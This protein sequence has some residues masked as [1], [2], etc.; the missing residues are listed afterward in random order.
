M[1]SQRRFSVKSGTE[2]FSFNVCNTA[3]HVQHA[4]SVLSQHTHVM[5]D[6][7]GQ[8]IGTVAGGLSLL[9]LGT[10]MPSSDQSIFVLDMVALQ[11]SVPART[12]LV[13]FL[14]ETDVT[15]VLFDGRMDKIEIDAALGI[16]FGAVTHA[17]GVV[18]IQLAEVLARTRILKETEL[19]RRRHLELGRFNADFLLR[20][21][22]LLAGIELVMG[23]D[24][25]MQ[26]YA[27]RVRLQK[28]GEHQLAFSCLRSSTHAGRDR[29][30]EGDA[31]GERKLSLD[32]SPNSASSTPVRSRGHP[33]L[34]VP[35]RQ[36]HHVW[37]CASSG[38]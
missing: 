27:S 17:G 16:D 22:S 29:L 31:Q 20:Q 8:A 23:M 2:S 3:E 12:L 26:R 28:D 24:K 7:E 9:C 13:K 30:R 14:T 36:F 18:D 38:S 21:S 1:S 33:R 25:C 6:S 15:K 11:H 35:L 37:K 4:L 32:A 10:P 5:L 19:D 34:G